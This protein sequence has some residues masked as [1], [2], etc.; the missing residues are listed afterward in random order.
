MLTAAPDV[1]FVPAHVLPLFTR[2]PASSPSTISGT[3]TIPRRT[4]TPT[5]AT[6][7]GLRA[8]TRRQAAAV[9]ADSEA[10]KADLVR[11]YG[12]QA[13]KI[14]VVYLGRDERF[15]AGD[16]SAAPGRRFGPKYDLAQRYF[17]Y[18]GHASAPQEP[19]TRRSSI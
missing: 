12:A 16:Q 6:W 5:G 18:V 2:G 13:D 19:R 11:A 15:V 8:G 3:C 7:T 10:T 17:L 9:L 4:R 1:L 14:H